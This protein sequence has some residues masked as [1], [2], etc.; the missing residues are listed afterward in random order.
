MLISFLK[1]YIKFFEI[2]LPENILEIKN[3][4]AEKS[5][6]IAQRDKYSS[7]DVL[8]YTKGTTKKDRDS[9]SNVYINS[10]VL[11]FFVHF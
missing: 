10:D 4:R 1:K 2:F 5:I 8:I 3:K 6:K 9:P 11:T 7:R